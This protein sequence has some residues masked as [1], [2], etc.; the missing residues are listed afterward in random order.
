MHNQSEQTTEQFDECLCLFFVTSSMSSRNIFASTHL[1]PGVPWRNSNRG[2]NCRTQTCSP[3]FT[4]TACKSSTNTLVL[5]RWTCRFTRFD[6][7]KKNTPLRLTYRSSV[8]DVETSLQCSEGFYSRRLVAIYGHSPPTPSLA[9]REVPWCHHHISQP[10]EQVQKS[11]RH[12]WSCVTHTHCWKISTRSSLRFNTSSLNV[13]RATRL[14]GD[15]SRRDDTALFR[16]SWIPWLH[17]YS[18]RHQKKYF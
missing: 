11:Q 18:N 6:A 7:G 4:Q 17:Q 3:M 1:W 16:A 5:N 10:G 9:G 2:Q 12:T 14:L 13:T 8:S 15:C